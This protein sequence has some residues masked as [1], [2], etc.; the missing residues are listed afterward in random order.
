M[1]ID[2]NAIGNILM[3][4]GLS[5]IVILALAWVVWN[6]RK[7]G[8]AD[9]AALQAKLDELQEKR[10]AEGRE[11]LNALNNTTNVLDDVLKAIQAQGANK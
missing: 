4:Q 10:I 1:V 2:F 9:I 3:E 5:G 6:M 8:R 11:S 7:E